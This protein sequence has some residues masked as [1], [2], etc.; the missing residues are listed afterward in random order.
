MIEGRLFRLCII[1]KVVFWTALGAILIRSIWAKA[2]GQDLPDPAA[3]AWI[4]GA[5]TG[6]QLGAWFA[7]WRIRRARLRKAA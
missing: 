2:T 5:L 6:L 7:W 1:L 3:L 4:V